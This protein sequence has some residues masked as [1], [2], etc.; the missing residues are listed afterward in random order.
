MAI[1]G[2]RTA[3]LQKR[4]SVLFALL[5]ADALADRVFGSTTLEI[6]YQGR[7]AVELH[8]LGGARNTDVTLLRDRDDDLRM[9]TPVRSR[10]FGA[11]ELE[12]FEI[13]LRL[14][15]QGHCDLWVLRPRLL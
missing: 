2:F 15:A 6:D 11:P 1:K 4:L 12:N 7:P 8:R 3:P 5:V 14:N 13:H 9:R 10:A